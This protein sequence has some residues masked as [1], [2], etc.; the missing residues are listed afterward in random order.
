MALRDLQSLLAK[1]YTDSSFRSNF[2]SRPEQIINNYNLSHKEKQD[3]LSLNPTL[4]EKFA[5]SLINKRA[6]F[7]IKYFSHSY[8][9]FGIELSKA[10]KQYVAINPHKYS[11]SVMSNLIDAFQFLKFAQRHSSVKYHIPKWGIALMKYELLN[12]QLRVKGNKI[13]FSFLIYPVNLLLQETHQLPRI[14]PSLA[15]WVSFGKY[16][17]HKIINFYRTT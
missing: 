10:I 9:L 2:T 7:I 4:I 13:Y 3:F 16:K 1:I 11:P 17:F 8:S 12:H 15:M 6:G 5:N 14:N